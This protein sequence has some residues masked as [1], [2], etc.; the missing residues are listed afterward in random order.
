MVTKQSVS[1]VILGSVHTVYRRQAFRVVFPRFE[2]SP[3]Y[4]SGCSFPFKHVLCSLFW[5]ITLDMFNWK[6]KGGR[7]GR[8]EEGGLVNELVSRC[9][10]FVGLCLSSRLWIFPSDSVESV[11]LQMHRPGHTKDFVN[12]ACKCW[13]SAPNQMASFPFAAAPGLSL[14]FSLSVPT[15]WRLHTTVPVSAR[16]LDLE[17]VLRSSD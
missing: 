4:Y 9:R 16:N 6:G 17:N 10:S 1:V 11:P 3:C 7:E 14:Y 15:P 5:L 12:T 13:Q 8:R 2:P